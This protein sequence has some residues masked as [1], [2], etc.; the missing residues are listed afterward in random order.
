[1][2]VTLTKVENIDLTVITPVPFIVYRLIGKL[3]VFFEVSGVQVVQHDSDQ[4]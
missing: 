1:M 4:F 3:N 2:R